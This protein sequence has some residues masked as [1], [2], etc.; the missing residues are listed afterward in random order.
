MPTTRKKTVSTSKELNPAKSMLLE[1]AWEVCNQ[2]GGIYTVIRSKVPAA[3]EVFEDNYCLI[4]PGIHPDRTAELDP[5]TE[6]TDLISR[7]AERMR[8][9]GFDVFYGN[10]LVTGRPKIVLFDLTKAL[11]QNI[12]YSKHLLSEHGIP[13]KFDDDLHSQVIAFSKM[14]ELFLEYLAEENTRGKLTLICHFHEW[15]AGIPILNIKQKNL[16]IRTV[17]TTHATMLGR[18]I[19]MNDPGF[20]ENL[21]S[22]DWQEQAKMYGIEA[23]AK[24]ERACASQADVLTTVSEVTGKECEYLLGKKPDHILPNG[25]NIKRFAAA[26]EVQILHQQFKEEINKFVLGHFFNSYSFDLDKT[27]YF[28]SSGRYE[29]H[30]KG[31]DLTL[32]AL[33][34]LNKMMKRAKL[35]VTVVMFLITKRA[36]WS[37]NPEVLESRAVLEELR[38]NTRAIQ[39]Q[40]GERLFMAAASSETDFRLPDLNK[41]VDDYWRLRY[42]RTVQTWKSPNWPIIVTHNLHD[43]DNDEVLNFLRTNKLIN[44]PLDRVKIVYHPDF[45]TS[46]NPL[47]GLD[48]SDFVRGCHLGIFPSYYEPWGYTPLESIAS[49]V[50][51]ITS[52]LSGFGDYVKQNLNTSFD[53]GVAVLNRDGRNYEKSV[54][55]LAKMMFS[56]VKES[57]IYRITQRNK[58][59][60]L[61]Q[62]F[63]WHFLIKEYIAAYKI[64]INKKRPRKK[65]IK[66]KP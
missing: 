65:A 11:N 38:H 45:M 19:A 24:I 18:I 34:K 27:L 12:E 13:E 33:N 7:A 62:K 16:P 41:M 37:I 5:I 46:T 10:W 30:N 29:Y 43:P 55:D 57:R 36:S 14:T 44:S 50:P 22:Y 66:K 47:L 35:D 26:H 28:F 56:F 15:M 51:T 23:I 3:K 64:A 40:V 25:L 53:Q 63:D 52:D 39:K 60:D 2:V 21:D 49:G 6:S 9:E 42:R 4:G 48:Y 20:Y 1:V 58:S 59:E 31:Y 61:A 32:E 54:D 8:K 17:F